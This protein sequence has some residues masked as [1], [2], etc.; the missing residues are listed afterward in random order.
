MKDT[1]LVVVRNRN[2]GL[3]GY[4][5]KDSNMTR[6]WQPGQEQKVPFGELKN[7]MFE[8]GGEYILRNLLLINDAPALEALNIEVEPEYYYTEK[9][10][11]DILFNNDNLDVLKDFL[12][13]APK[14]CIEICKDIAV[15]EELPD[16]RKR[17]IISKATGFNI[18]SAINLNKQLAEDDDDVHTEAPKKERRVKTE[19]ATQ[20]GGRR[21]KVPEYKVVQ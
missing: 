3:T 5:L 17:D 18:T 13:F 19:D 20:Q 1:D 12:D 6:T 16:N 21:V 8:P 11:R 15:K 14:G 7:V 4:Q 9:E 10:I 2:R